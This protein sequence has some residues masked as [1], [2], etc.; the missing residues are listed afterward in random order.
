MA[1]SLIKPV[2]RRERLT[3]ST[4][5]QVIPAHD[6]PL[7]RPQIDYVP[8]RD[9]VGSNRQTRRRKAQLIARHADQIETRGIDLPIW[10]MRSGRIIYG[11]DTHAAYRLKKRDTVP[12]IFIE[13]RPEAELEAIG[14]WLE[15]F[16][17]DGEWDLEALKVAFGTVL[18]E[19]PD[20]LRNSYWSLAEVDLILHG[21]VKSAGAS[22]VVA[23]E[24]EKAP[25]VT[26]EGDL[27]V[28]PS[29]HRA[30]C[31]NSR[32]PETYTR[33]MAGAIAPLMA[34]DPPF[35][36]SVAAISSRHEEWREGS[37]MTEAQTLS[38]FEQFMNAA[39]P[40]LKDGALVY[41][42]I[43]HKGM[44]PLLGAMRS[45][46]LKQKNICTWDKGSGV[47]GFLMNVAE[48]LVIAQHGRA[49]PVFNP[50]EGFKTTI[51]AAPGY[52][53]SRPDRKEALAAHACTKPLGILMPI[54]LQGSDIGDVC[55][56][57]FLGSGSGM[58]AAERVRRRC[59]GVEIEPRFIDT[60]VRRMRQ[61]TGAYPVHEESGLSFESLA[62]ERGVP[63]P[64][65][66]ASA[67]SDV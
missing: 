5:T 8:I 37:G 29:G 26:R 55:L 38:F 16:D 63:L 23:D 21:P 36:T 1:Q 18:A 52:S 54:L 48:Y 60:T 22:V 40:H 14:L 32:L 56:D 4:P 34:V 25:A 61:L 11:H 6:G 10:A 42:F 51:W 30:L 27:F 65:N 3:Q 15:R 46:G 39:K 47:G 19:A 45:V 62:A 2:R 44:Y 67:D 20:L 31:G 28:W 58:L 66:S 41:S 59:Y 64:T 9:L 33:L 50:V 12:V 13:D 35:G 24:P 49:K 43:D 57:P 7:I 17:A 53:Q